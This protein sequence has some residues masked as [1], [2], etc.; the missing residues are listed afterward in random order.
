MTEYEDTKYIEI[1]LNKENSLANNYASIMN[2]LDIVIEAGYANLEDEQDTERIN[3]LRNAYA[4]I[5][6]KMLWG[7]LP[8]I[9]KLE[10]FYNDFHQ[11]LD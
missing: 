2:N 7:I 9:K 10:R 1:K 5:V 6:Q 3:M 8:E 11:N 4:P